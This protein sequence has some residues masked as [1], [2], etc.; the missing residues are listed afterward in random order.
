MY[1]CAVVDALACGATYKLCR[2]I[3]SCK[4]PNLQITSAG[5]KYGADACTQSP[6]S[7]PQ[8]IAV[9]SSTQQDTLSSFSNLGSCVDVSRHKVFEGGAQNGRT[10]YAWHV[11]FTQ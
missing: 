7:N 3:C 1:N 4:H 10:R 11:P 2:L 5:N 6:A 9:A 8:A